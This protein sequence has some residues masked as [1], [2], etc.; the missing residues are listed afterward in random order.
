M[1]I[2]SRAG[3]VKYE[4]P[5]EDPLRDV[6]SA[7]IQRQHMAN[8]YVQISIHT[9]NTMTLEVGDWIEVRNCRY[10]IRAVSDITREG[11]E[12]FTYNIT[13]YGVMYDLM[14][15]AFRDTPINGRSPQNTFDLTLSLKDFIKVIIHNVNR[16][17]DISEESVEQSPWLFDEDGCPATDPVTMS[18]DKQNCLTALQNIVQEFDVEF[19]ITQELNETYG[20]WQSTIHV[21][22]FGSVV[23]STPFAYGDGNGLYQ[24]QETKV[25]DSCIVNRLWAEGSTENILSGYRGYSMRLQLPRKEIPLLGTSD[26][27]RYSRREHTIEIDNEKIVFAAGYPIGIDTDDERYVDEDNLYAGS[28]DTEHGKWKKEGELVWRYSPFNP[29]GLITKYGILESSEVFDDVMPSPTFKV[30]KPFSAKSRLQFFCDVEFQLDAIWTDTFGDFREWCLLKTQLAPSLLQYQ[31]S[32]MV[33][34]SGDE[35]GL[36]SEYRRNIGDG[37][38]ERYTDPYEE[39][40]QQH[41]S[42]VPNLPA[43]FSQ[44]VYA[45]YTIFREYLVSDTNSKYL[46]DG[47]QMAFVDGKC[48][49]IDFDI[50][51]NGFVFWDDFTAEQLSDVAFSASKSYSVGDYCIYNNHPYRFTSAHSGIW[52]MSHVTEAPFGLLVINEKEEQDTGDIFPSEDEFGAFRIA[53]GD[54]FKLVNIYFPYNYYEDAEEELWF[55]AYERF[56]NVK[57]ALLQ[58]KLSFD[59]MFVSENKPIFEGILPGDYIT[60]SDDRFGLTNK[61]M[62]VIQVDCN[63][64]T[65]IDY[66]ITLQ[67]VHKQRTRT[68]LSIHDY[69]EVMRA[70]EDVN[71]DNPRYRRNNRT[72][73]SGAISRIT[74]N[75]Y[76]RQSRV[77]DQFI[78]TRMLADGAISRAKIATKAINTNLLDDQAVTNAK[79][80]AGDVTIDR[81][82]NAVVEKINKTVQIDILR[83]FVNGIN[84]DRHYS[85]DIDFSD[86]KLVLKNISVTDSLYKDILKSVNNVWASDEEVVIDFSG[87]EYEPEQAYTI[88]AKLGLEGDM[89]YEVVK[90]GEDVSDAH[91]KVGKVSAE[92]SGVRTYTQEISKAHTSNGVIMDGNGNA[93]L[94]IKNGILRGL[95]KFAGLKDGSGNDTDLISLLGS[96]PT[97]SGGLRKQVS[98]KLNS[99]EIELTLTADGGNIRL[100]QNN[101]PLKIQNGKIVIG[102]AEL[103][104]VSDSDRFVHTDDQDWSTLLQSVTTLNNRM[105]V[106]VNALDGKKIQVCD[107]HQCSEQEINFNVNQI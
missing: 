102:N 49:G 44:D 103:T 84:A 60:I 52:N 101:L 1:V 95:L 73:G 105:G 56:E 43:G 83:G 39:W 65:N 53:P 16:G 25:D 58:Y 32:K 80:K 93:V 3:V 31:V 8:D 40:R 67:N 29:S 72:S 47:G 99:N 11:E 18:F 20:V 64:L 22:E 75:G 6:T 98:E 55:A 71:L 87:A 74:A 90:S 82:A 77:A 27:R 7:K 96:T 79:I 46:I 66:Q 48:A 4:L 45:E 41:Q 104:P 33:Y 92:I 14:R 23:N 30:I 68:G 106:L 42:A 10:S 37:T 21:G 91:L 13:F 17:E 54:K 34:D 86:N 51:E 12:L 2:Y 50:A 24:L 78:A 69:R 85:G 70:L 63:L 36:W 62:R 38:I 35:D 26:T 59:P 61:K 9:N 89:Q 28:R 94:D 81:L 57:F 107:D 100:G 88:Y 5:Y 76:I 19:R 97:A 15:Y